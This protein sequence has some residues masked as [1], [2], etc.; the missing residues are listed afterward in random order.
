ML[1]LTVSGDAPMTYCDQGHKVIS[2]QPS[3]LC[4]GT[5]LGLGSGIPQLMICSQRAANSLG[6]LQ[7]LPSQQAALPQLACQP[8]P[9][10]Q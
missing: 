7:L 2:T 3:T 1:F 5:I 8:A 4:I 6:G 10:Q 9:V